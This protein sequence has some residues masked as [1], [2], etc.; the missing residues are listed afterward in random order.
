MNKKNIIPLQA[1]PVI[2][3][4]S[5]AAIQNGIYLSDNLCQCEHGQIMCPENRNCHCVDGRPRCVE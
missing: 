3:Q 2:R 4:Y 5:T 1:K